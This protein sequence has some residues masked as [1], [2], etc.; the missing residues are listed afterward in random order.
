MKM[1]SVYNILYF[2]TLFNL[3]TLNTDKNHKFAYFLYV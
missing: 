2:R 1:I 3:L